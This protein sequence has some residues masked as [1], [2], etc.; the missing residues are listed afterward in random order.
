MK[1][2]AV[3]NT[4]NAAQTIKTAL[5]SVKW[6][7]QIVVVD[8]QST[9]KTLEI[10]KKYT[11]QVFTTKDAGYVEPARNLAISKAQ[12][13]WVL[14]ID[15]DEE[16]PVSLKKHLQALM[17]KPA[18][19]LV[20]GYYLPRQNII[21]NK[22]M[23]GTGWWPDYQLR[24][25]QKD[26]VFWPKTIHAEPKIT[27]EVKYLPA[28]PAYALI[29]HHYQTIEQYLKRLDRYTSLEAQGIKAVN[30][31]VKL[32]EA[33][34]L[35]SFLA[36]FLQRL[37]AQQGLEEGMHGTGLALLQSMYQLVVKLKLWQD[38]GFKTQAND[39]QAAVQVLQQ[40]QQ[41]LNYWLADWQLKQATGWQKLWLRIKRK[42]RL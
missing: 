23:K 19:D 1:I 38:Q 26:Q 2:S 21:F 32:N 6:C 17:D 3:I 29:H 18:L 31:P 34:F 28:K 5:T 11:D 9:D 39:P 24:F 35:Q 16:L 37:F 25:F 36:E 12:H 14:L 27:G 30:K 40:F 33:E 20:A 10:V 42:Y 22:T 4:K 7:D 8:M 15:A 41:D 13:D